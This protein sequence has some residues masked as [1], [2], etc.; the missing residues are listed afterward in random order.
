MV[1]YAGHKYSSHIP[2]GVELDPGLV[3]WEMVGVVRIMEPS[4]E[5]YFSIQQLLLRHRSLPL[6][7]NLFKYLTH[8]NSIEIWGL[9]TSL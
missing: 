2:W 8:R 3:G 7:S 5:T 9:A 6:A 1:P 4:L